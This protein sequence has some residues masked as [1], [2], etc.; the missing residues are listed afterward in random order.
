MDVFAE[1][2]FFDSRMFRVKPKLAIPMEV[3][4][5]RVTQGAQIDLPNLF[6]Y[7]NR[8]VLLPRSL[9]ELPKIKRFMDINPKVKVE[10]AGHM[11]QPNKPP[12]KENTSEWQLSVARA[13]AI[14]QYLIDAGVAPERVTYKGYGN[15]QMRFPYA[16]SEK[17][18]EANRRVEIRILDTG[19]E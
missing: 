6:F 14:Y 3:P 7:G 1:G 16:T 9:P 10:I 8:D 12:V 19:E 11:N 4:L 18:Q 2:F 15:H 13:K 5:L 17:D